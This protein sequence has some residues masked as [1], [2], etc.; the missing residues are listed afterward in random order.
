MINIEYVRKMPDGSNVPRSTFGCS[1]CKVYLC[2]VCFRMEDEDGK[3]HKDAWDHRA[4]TR[5]LMARCI[6]L[7]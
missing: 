6:A 5:G 2:R 7:E 3:P 4:A 1:V